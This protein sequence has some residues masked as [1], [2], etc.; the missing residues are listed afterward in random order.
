MALI[1]SQI[2]IP[3]N[4]N[5]W[6]KSVKEVTTIEYN[7]SVRISNWYAKIRMLYIYIYIYIS[8]KS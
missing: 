3:V 1:K 4:Q 7:K 8:G 2:I 6:S 5:N